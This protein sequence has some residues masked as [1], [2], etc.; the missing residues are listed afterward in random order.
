MEEQEGSIELFLVVETGDAALERLSAA[1]AA[2]PIASVL[3]APAAGQSMQTADIKPLVERAQS[4][5]A[6]ALLLDD[7]EL[8]KRLGADGVHLSPGKALEDRYRKARE[9]LG[10]RA[11]I[12]VQPGKSRHD[13]MTL[14]E[15]GAEY[16]AFG[17]P[18]GVQDSEAARERRLDLVAW[19]A[20]IFEVP[21]V[22]L[23]VET[24][25]DATELVRAGADFIGIKLAAGDNVADI[26]QRVRVM[27]DAV[28]AA[29][30]D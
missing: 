26:S 27:A 18:E 24:P 30:A 23:D 13:A 16:V 29:L 11:I 3:I 8:A 6:A 5:G 2:A 12:G 7:A 21:C 9:I 28:T 15:A 22:A 4:H 20:E 17:I 1:L 10:P 14:A 19:W 25:E